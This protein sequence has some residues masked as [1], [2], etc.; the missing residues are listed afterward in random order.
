MLPKAVFN[1]TKVHWRLATIY[2][3]LTDLARSRHAN[4][5]HMLGFILSEYAAVAL[6][7]RYTVM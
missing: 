5:F 4:Q 6:I 2:L 7:A 1:L 3:L